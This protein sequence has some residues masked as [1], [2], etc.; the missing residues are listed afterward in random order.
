MKQTKKQPQMK[1]WNTIPLSF[2]A[3]PQKPL[4]TPNSLT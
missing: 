2:L 1:L 4:L 3:T